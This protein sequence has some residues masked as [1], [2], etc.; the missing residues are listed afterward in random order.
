M[1]SIAGCI[2]YRQTV[3]K[4]SKEHEMAQYCETPTK[5]FECGEALS[6][7]L[8]VKL[9]SLKLVAAGASDVEIGTIEE[10]SFAAGDL[11]SVRLRTAQGTRKMVA[12]EAITAGNQV[13][14]S[15]GGKV[16]PTGTVC[17]GTALES[18]TANNDIIEVLPGPNTDI[19]AAIAG[20]NATSF[21]VDADSA[22]PKLAIAGQ[23]AGTGNFTT[24][25]KPES[26]LSADNTI[27]VP[28]SDGDTVAAVALAQT[29]LAKTLGVGTKLLVA[30]VAA[31]G[32]TQADAAEL[33]GVV[34]TATGDGAVGVK[35]PAAAAGTLICVYNLSAAGG[36][37]VYP[38]TDDDINDGA[39]NSA[40]TIEGKTLAVFIAVDAT[41]WSGIFTANT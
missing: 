41:T 26:T 19:S 1:A 11:R 8:R 23:A 39:A 12:S 27:V 30:E 35:L 7:Y 36:L 5:T 3:T 20:T 25:L 4:S 34:N 13:Y 9:S 29:L 22:A 40:V 37:K 17:C 16:A 28:E 2:Q 31:A 33:T 21:A 24:T 18:A 14:A 6:Q 15:A 10:D 32:T 38:N